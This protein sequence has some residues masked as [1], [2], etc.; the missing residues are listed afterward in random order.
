[1]NELLLTGRVLTAWM[2]SSNVMDCCGNTAVQIVT[3]ATRPLVTL[4]SDFD[5]V[6]VQIFSGTD[7]HAITTKVSVHPCFP[8]R[9]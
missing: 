3:S 9:K 7:F 2:A 6:I 1:M 5:S 8:Q 4:G